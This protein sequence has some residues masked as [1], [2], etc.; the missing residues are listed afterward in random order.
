MAQEILTVL[1]ETDWEPNLHWNSLP[2]EFDEDSPYDHLAS[3]GK[4]TLNVSDLDFY[5]ETKWS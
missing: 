5:R 1:E 3:D 4:T 2:S